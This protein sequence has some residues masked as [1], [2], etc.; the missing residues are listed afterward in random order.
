MGQAGGAGCGIKAV[1]FDFGGVLAEEGFREGLRAIGR[2]YG[3][4][5]EESFRVGRDAA[6]RGGYTTGAINEAD[7]W[8]AFRARTGIRATDDELR[9]EVLS[10]FTLR[11]RM[12]RCARRVKERGFPVYIL[13]DQSHWLDE[14]DTARGGRFMGIFDSVFVSYKIG[15]DKTDPTLFQDVCRG[16]GV[17]PCEALLIDDN[18]G[19][20]ERARGV[21]MRAILFEDE[22]GFMREIGA[23][24]GEGVCP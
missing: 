24:L 23:A 5:P 3:L 12:L 20:V 18:P 19:N 7:Y 16:L 1:L 17:S 11:P 10:R 2:K 21:G 13:S 8:E 4:D 22:E 14:L 15:K 6:Y 9:H